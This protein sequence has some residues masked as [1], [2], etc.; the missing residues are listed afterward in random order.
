[1]NEDLQPI[2]GGRATPNY[3]PMTE[4]HAEA[5]DEKCNVMFSKALCLIVHIISVHTIQLHEEIWPVLV[6][7]MVLGLVTK[8]RDWINEVD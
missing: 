6:R 8:C 2:C 3:R 7:P 5:F 4:H 1:M